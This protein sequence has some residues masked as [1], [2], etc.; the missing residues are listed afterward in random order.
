MMEVKLIVKAPDGIEK[1]VDL[2]DK[3]YINLEMI[4]KEVEVEYLR[5]QLERSNK[6]K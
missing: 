5:R 4:R 2:T 1:V 3:R 6:A